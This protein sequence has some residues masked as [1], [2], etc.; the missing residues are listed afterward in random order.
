MSSVC[1][2]GRLGGQPGGGG[3]GS[4]CRSRASRSVG[5]GAGGSAC[6]KESWPDP[7]LLAAVHPLG[8]R[9]GFPRPSPRVQRGDTNLPRPASRCNTE[10]QRTKPYL[11]VLGSYF[12]KTHKIHHPEQTFQAHG[13]VCGLSPEGNRFSV[14]CELTHSLDSRAVRPRGSG[15]SHLWKHREHPRGT[16][17]PGMACAAL[18]PTWLVGSSGSSAR[19]PLLAQAWLPAPCVTSHRGPGLAS[20]LLPL[21]LLTFPSITS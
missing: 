2:R 9:F 19:T 11:F 5:R 14:G 16:V 7:C 13:K 10:A 4:R 3:G 6:R 15:R 20:V 21:M 1:A 12:L 18:W 17:G 8:L